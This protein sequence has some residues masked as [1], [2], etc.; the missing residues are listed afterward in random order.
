M[1]SR[2]ERFGMIPAA[3]RSSGMKAKPRRMARRGEPMVTPLPST[4]MVPLSARS[5][6]NSSLAVS[7]RPEP[8]S[9]ARPTTCPPAQSHAD[10]RYRPAAAQAVNGHEGGLVRRPCLGDRADLRRVGDKL[11]RVLADHPG[12]QLDPRQ[13]VGL[14]LPDQPAVAKHRDAVADAVN[15]VQKVRDEYDPDPLLAQAAHQGEELLDLVFVQAG[16]RLVEDQHPGGDVQRPRDAHHL[17]DRDGIAGNLASYVDGKCQPGHRRL[18][19][20]GHQ[21]P[22]DGPQARRLAAKADILGH[23]Q[24]RDQVHLLV[25]GADAHGLGLHGACRLY[26][27]AFQQHTAGVEGINAGEH[28]DQRA[29][30]RAVLAHQGVDFPAAKGEVHN[31]QGLHARKALG[32]APHLQ[33]YAVGRIA[34]QYFRLPMTSLAT[35]WS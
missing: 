27:L 14:V 25:D 17:L 31:I 5:M 6:P 34:H 19:P 15:L 16:R 21:A 23:R 1:F 13:L 28:L 32:D 8:S 9:P 20:P 30:A 12:D 7:V 4:R 10:R 11:P 24:V 3:R 2:T 33:Q 18:G 26:S 22:A 35:D 29:L